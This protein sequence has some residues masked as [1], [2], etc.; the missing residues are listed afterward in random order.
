MRGLAAR[1]PDKPRS[2][3]AARRNQ[4][5]P[6]LTRV[7]VPL[8][9][10]L[11]TQLNEKLLQDFANCLRHVVFA[12]T[13]EH[14]KLFSR[15]AD[16]DLLRAHKVDRVKIEAMVYAARELLQVLLHETVSEAVN[17]VTGGEIVADPIEEDV[18]WRDPRRGWQGVLLGL[19]EGLCVSTPSSHTSV[20]ARRRR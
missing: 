12:W 3:H 8:L 13:V 11:L 18:V 17:P 20:R 6:R 10:V 15:D 14:P 2:R 5:A 16:A 7:L 1:P 4:I 9:A 19:L